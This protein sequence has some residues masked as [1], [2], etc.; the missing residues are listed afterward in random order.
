MLVAD[1]YKIL[2]TALQIRTI[3]TRAERDG[4][5]VLSSFQNKNAD[6]VD[7]RRRIQYQRFFSI[8]QQGFAW[9]RGWPLSEKERQVSSLLASCGPL[10]DDLFDKDRL[11]ANQII[12]VTTGINTTENEINPHL[13]L[14]GELVKEILQK[15]RF[16]EK[17]L[18]ETERLCHAQE[19]ACR[20]SPDNR[21]DHVL[22]LTAARG[23]ATA[24]L[25]RLVMD[26]DLVAGEWAMLNRL[27]YLAQL[28]DDLFDWQEDQLHG[29]IT[30]FLVI[31]ETPAFKDLFQQEFL[32]FSRELKTL[33]YAVKSLNRFGL[34]M[35][36]SLAAFGVAWRW[37]EPVMN[38]NRRSV[39]K[40]LTF[41]KCDMEKFSNQLIWL[42]ESSQMWT[43]FKNS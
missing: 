17:F 36:M 41:P 31:G 9:M 12:Q 19:V 32:S 26:H 22:A 40:E 21:P 1:G 37:F 33:P 24:C 25:C 42:H 16:R 7:H 8:L 28:M 5:H 23:G 43:V 35:A 34:L 4:V 38:L 2:K 3:T 29:H 15:I 13:R 39:S 14:Y 18:L 6:L 27:G 20:I 10:F 11:T 30:S